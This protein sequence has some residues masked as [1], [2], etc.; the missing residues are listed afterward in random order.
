MRDMN[1]T[2]VEKLDELRANQRYMWE[3][4]QWYM[5]V[6]L[7]LHGLTLWRTW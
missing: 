2:Q 7:V 4:W 5:T 1:T 3:W 6:S